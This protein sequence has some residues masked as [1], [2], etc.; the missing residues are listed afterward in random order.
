M[1]EVPTRAEVPTMSADDLALALGRRDLE[2]LQL[3]ARVRALEELLA[4][5]AADDEPAS[6]PTG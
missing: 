6:E 1:A 2:I 4:A 3:Q 5:R